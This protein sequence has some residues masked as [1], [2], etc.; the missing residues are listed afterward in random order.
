[1]LSLDAHEETELVE[2]LQVTRLPAFVVLHPGA[3]V[4]PAAVVQA[5]TPAHLDAATRELPPQ[6]FLDADF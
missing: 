3:P 5:A 4:A 6:L 1:M 2:L